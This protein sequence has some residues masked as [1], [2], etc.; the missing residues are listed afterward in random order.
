V[1]IE[2]LPNLISKNWGTYKQITSN[3]L[4]SYSNG[5]YSYNLVNGARHLTTYQKY[6]GLA[7]TY[8]VM[9][10]VRYTFN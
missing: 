4:L 1:D 10:S 2:N 9:F 7:S 6:Q 5:Q 8:K 3:T